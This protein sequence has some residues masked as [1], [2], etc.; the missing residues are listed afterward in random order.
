MRCPECRR[1]GFKGMRGV[2]IHLHAGCPAVIC[3]MFK[4][5]Y[6]MD[7]LAE[8]FDKPKIRIEEIIRVEGIKRGRDVQI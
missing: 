2:S 7:D 6:S 1:E 8:K 4:D 5:G 3:N